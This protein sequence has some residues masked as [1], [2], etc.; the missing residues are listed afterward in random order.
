MGERFFR[1]I[2][3]GLAD[4][5]PDASQAPDAWAFQARCTQ[6]FAWTWVVRGFAA[7]T[8][9]CYTSLLERVLNRSTGCGTSTTT[10]PLFGCRLR[11]SA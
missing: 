1:L 3:G 8:V 10:H 5:A 4:P 11:P 2:E 6:A 7:T 9:G